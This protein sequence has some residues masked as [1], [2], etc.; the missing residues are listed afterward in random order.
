MDN[1][2]LLGYIATCFSAISLLPEVLKALKTH[3]LRDLAWGMLALMIV[4]SSLWMIYGY[5]KGVTPLVIS[6]GMNLLFELFLV[7]LKLHYSKSKK[8]LLRPAVETEN[9]SSET[10]TDLR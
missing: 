6:A 2:E 1:L 8:P 10:T 5:A 9:V 4:S 7:G 3:H